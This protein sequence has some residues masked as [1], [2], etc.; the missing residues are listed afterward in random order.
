MISA[1]LFAGLAMQLAQSTPS[2]T[3]TARSHARVPQKAPVGKRV[4]RAL[5]VGHP[6]PHSPVI[7]HFHG[8]PWVPEVTVPSVYMDAT[9]LSIYVGSISDVYQDAYRTP[10]AFQALLR[11]AGAANSRRPVILSSF[12][13][14]YGAIRS[15]LRHSYQRIDS[16][17]LMDGLHSDYVGKNPNPAELDVFLKFAG[18]AAQGKKRMLITHSEVFPGTFAS[19]TETTDWILQKLRI[20]RHCVLQLGPVGMM[21]VTDARKGR[22]AVFGFAGDSAP[23]HVDHLHGMSTWLKVL[24]RM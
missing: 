8:D 24:R 10:A 22:L 21:Q 2:A 23:D 17:L 14:G 6:G 19:T 9:I 15:I 16:V 20:D 13:A 18:D 5:V 7:L 11:E 4:G 3:D 12:S 1:L